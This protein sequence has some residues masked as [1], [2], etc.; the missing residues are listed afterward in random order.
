MQLLIKLLLQYQDHLADL[1]KSVEALAEEL[2]EYDLIQS[3]PGIG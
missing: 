2:L 3:I 1:N